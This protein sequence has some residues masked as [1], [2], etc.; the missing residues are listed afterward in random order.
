MAVVSAQGTTVPFTPGGEPYPAFGNLVPA[1]RSFRL[2]YPHPHDHEITLV[3]VLVGGNSQD[4]TPNAALN[5]ANI[6]DGRLEVTFQDANPSGEEFGYF[7]SHSTLR[8][9][10]ARRFQI[11][12]LGCVNECVRE[13]P[14]EVFGGGPFQPP[15]SQPLL[16]LVGF[17]LFFTGA[18][19]REL[20]RIGVWFRNNELHV[21]L[22][23]RSGG[24]PF[25]YLVDFVVIPTT[26]LNVET[27]NESGTADTL[28]TIPLP[29]P[30][31]AHSLLTGWRFNFRGQKD[32]R[33]LDCG[34]LRENDR[35]TV[36]YSDASGGEDFDWRVDW[37]HV[38]PM[39]LAPPNL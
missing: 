33:I 22:R 28:G 20:D 7:V 2:T 30:P 8:A 21:V 19:D 12:D 13:L 24:E 26:G 18:R 32:R 16:A 3:Q 31:R 39:V 37:S 6:P 9:P 27:N 10:G 5:P 1:L 35:F 4:L 15:I 25:G 14:S 29:T 36:F 34:V 17:K 11:R 23:D 38:S